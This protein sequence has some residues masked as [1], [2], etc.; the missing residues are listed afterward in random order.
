MEG[1]LPATGRCCCEVGCQIGLTAGITEASSV[2]LYE[3][4]T[5]RQLLANL[6]RLQFHAAAC[7]VTS[8]V[9]CRVPT[10]QTLNRTAQ[11]GHLE[12]IQNRHAGQ[13]VQ[14]SPCPSS[15]LPHMRQN[16]CF[17]TIQLKPISSGVT[18]VLPKLTLLTLAVEINTKLCS[19]RF[20]THS[21]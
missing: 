4:F 1:F 15:A 14:R 12:I 10:Y 8:A 17:L 11:L 2:R 13:T 9:A 18:D 21:D 19:E 6:M 5:M 7:W 20:M 3:E 16:T